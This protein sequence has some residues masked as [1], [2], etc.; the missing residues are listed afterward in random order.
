MIK[1][2]ILVTN[3]KSKLL[4]FIEVNEFNSENIFI[5]FLTFEELKFDKSIFI[6]LVNVENLF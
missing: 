1:K 5:I 2:D 6:I 3:D 4:K